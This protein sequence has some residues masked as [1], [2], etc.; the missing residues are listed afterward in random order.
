[1]EAGD[2]HQGRLVRVWEAQLA[3]NSASTRTL[4]IALSTIQPGVTLHSTVW[5]SVTWHAGWELSDVT[6]FQAFDIKCQQN[7]EGEFHWLIYVTLEW[8]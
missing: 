4:S 3:T 6:R 1:M 8:W 2:Y 7:A 5:L